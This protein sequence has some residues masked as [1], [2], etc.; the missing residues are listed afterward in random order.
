MAKDEVSKK[1]VDPQKHY[2][3]VRMQQGRTVLDANGNDDEA[4][5]DTKKPPQEGKNTVEKSKIVNKKKK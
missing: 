1:A 5:N 3:G 4:S 2:V